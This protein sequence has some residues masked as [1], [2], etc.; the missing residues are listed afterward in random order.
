MTTPFELDAQRRE[1]HGTRASRRLRRAGKIPAVL[2]GAGQAP[3]HLALD[4]DQVFH[5]LENEAFHAAIIT[6]K[7][8]GEPTQAIL[9][10]V[11]YH[12]HKPRVL[13]VDLQRVSASERLHIKVPLHFIGEEDAP[14]VRL[15]GGIV[16]HQLTEV[17]ISCL[18]SRLPEYLEVD[19]SQLKLHDSVHLSDIPLPEGVEITALTHGGDDLAVAT[20]VAV[21]GAV[22]EVEAEVEEGAEA[23]AEGAGEADKD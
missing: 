2:Y 3:A 8:D 21:R 17:D 9:R 6:V 22:E 23:P 19:V 12:P 20:I 7:V 14:G 5:D 15:Q 1:A 18:P 11:Q 4:H 13:H 10:D 16:S